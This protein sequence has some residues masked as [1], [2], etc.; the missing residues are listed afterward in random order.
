[1]STCRQAIAARRKARN[2]PRYKALKSGD[3][4]VRAARYAQKI[5][6]ENMRRQRAKAKK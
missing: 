6:N 3:A 1:M 2:D 4:A 5:A